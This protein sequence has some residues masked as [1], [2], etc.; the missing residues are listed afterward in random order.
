MGPEAVLEHKLVNAVTRLGGMCIKQTGQ[1]GIPDRLVILSDQPIGCPARCIFIEL[2]AE[3]GRLSAIQ[4]HQIQ[5]L[6]ALGC[7]VRVLRGSGDVSAFIQE[8]ERR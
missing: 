2:K 3:Q 1:M 4:K 8:L 6:R 5:R 7:D